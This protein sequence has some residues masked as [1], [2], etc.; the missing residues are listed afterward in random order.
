MFEHKKFT[1]PIAK[2]L[3]VF[4]LLDVRRA[5]IM[6]QISRS[7]CIRSKGIVVGCVSRYTMLCLGL[8]Y[9]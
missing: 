2:P 8:F 7:C 4:L 9:I 5:E 3:P 1:T 6:D